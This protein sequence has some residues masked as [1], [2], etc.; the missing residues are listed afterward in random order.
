MKIIIIINIHLVKMNSGVIK[1]SMEESVMNS[2][3]LSFS[4]YKSLPLL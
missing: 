2:K 1:T 3:K 4:K